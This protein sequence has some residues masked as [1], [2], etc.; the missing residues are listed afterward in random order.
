MFDQTSPRVEYVSGRRD[1]LILVPVCLALSELP[2]RGQKAGLGPAVEGKRLSEPADVRLAVV[3]LHHVV[4]RL[5]LC[6][7]HRAPGG[8]Q[9]GPVGGVAVHRLEEPTCREKSRPV[10][11]V[12]GVGFLDLGNTNY[13]QTRF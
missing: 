10:L 12:L 2:A 3:V 8:Q 5:Q 13:S 1:E 7:E 6:V 11:P 9:L 4:E